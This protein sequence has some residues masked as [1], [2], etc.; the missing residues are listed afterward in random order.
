MATNIT[1]RRNKDGSFAGGG[2]GDSFGDDSID[3]F[4]A[5]AGA[6]AGGRRGLGGGIG[7]IGGIGGGGG[8]VAGGFALRD[9]K[10]GAS[11][12]HTAVNSSPSASEEE[13][14]T[15]NGIV[16]TTN[17]QVHYDRN[18]QRKGSI[19]HDRSGGDGS[20]MGMRTSISGSL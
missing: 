4:G 5:A 10:G 19:S 1:S 20:S 8:G 11:K 2:L 9:L 17:V 13:I 14:M 15:Y 18:S 16:R 6:G 3:G 12:A 7:G